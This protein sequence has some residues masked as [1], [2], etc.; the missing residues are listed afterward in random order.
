MIGSNRQCNKHDER[1]RDKKMLEHPQIS[2]WLSA[3]GKQE[4]LKHKNGMLKD[5]L[6]G[7]ATYEI[8]KLCD[9]LNEK[10][11]GWAVY[12]LLIPDRA[13]RAGTSWRRK[14]ERYNR[15][16]NRF[17]EANRKV[18]LLGFQINRLVNERCKE[19]DIHMYFFDDREDI[20]CALHD[21]FITNKN[22]PPNVTLTLMKM[23]GFQAC[24][25]KARRGTR[26]T[27]EA[28]CEF[29]KRDDG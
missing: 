18:E 25:G 15:I 8:E 24:H 19:D 6:E 12:P 9:Q 4:N 27:T 28:F 3:I 11:P 17:K 29:P 21:H 14:E 23:N 1:N 2:Q 22:L 26:S 5:P 7:L 13:G 16:P 10:K 20:L